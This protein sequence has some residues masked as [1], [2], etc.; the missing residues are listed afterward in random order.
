MLEWKIEDFKTHIRI[1]HPNE[2]ENYPL[3]YVKLPDSMYFMSPTI[4]ELWQE[5]SGIKRE[6]KGDY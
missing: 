2:Y 6:F 3:T 1:L 5:W 4:D